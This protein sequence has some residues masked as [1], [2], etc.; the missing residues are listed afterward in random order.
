MLSRVCFPPTIGSFYRLKYPFVFLSVSD[1]TQGDLT[2]KLLTKTDTFN[3]IPY[4]GIQCCCFSALGN[5]T[6]SLMFSIRRK[7][8][9]FK[10]YPHLY[11]FTHCNYKWN[12]TYVSIAHYFTVPRG[13]ELVTTH[14]FLFSFSVGAPILRT[15]TINKLFFCSFLPL[16][17]L[18]PFYIWFQKP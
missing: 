11:T 8:G 10:A 9:A 7:N 2:C 4:L 15:T 14:C 6:I 13:W 12:M 1:P 16:S 18:L 5:T 3:F 17:S